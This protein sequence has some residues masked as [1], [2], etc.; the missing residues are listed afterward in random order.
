MKTKRESVKSN[1]RDSKAK[2]IVYL[3]EKINKLCEI[4]PRFSDKRD[5]NPLETIV[6]NDSIDY[7]NLSCK[8]LFSKEDTIASH[9]IDFLERYDMLYDLLENVLAKKIN[10][11]NVNV[12]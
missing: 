10:I 3:I 11:N 2:Y 8:I 9:E 1:K 5:I 7:K 12:D 4:Y 6:R